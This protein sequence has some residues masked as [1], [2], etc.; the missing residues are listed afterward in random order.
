MFA[1]LDNSQSSKSSFI[2]ECHINPDGIFDDNFLLQGRRSRQSRS[3]RSS[4]GLEEEEE[5]LGLSRRAKKKN[6][7]LPEWE[8]SSGKCPMEYSNLRSVDGNMS[9]QTSMI[10][11]RYF[12][13]LLDL[14]VNFGKHQHVFFSFFFLRT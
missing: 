4:F 5:E 13:T 8:M 3:A 10:R 7:R 1:V 11:I 2:R 14:S 12:N 6:Y 9:I